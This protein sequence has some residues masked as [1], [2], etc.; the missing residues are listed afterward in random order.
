[1]K[2]KQVVFPDI[3]LN[4]N[5]LSPESVDD[6]AFRVLRHLRNVEINWPG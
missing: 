1:M 5:K 3:I 6:R 2:Y 4:D